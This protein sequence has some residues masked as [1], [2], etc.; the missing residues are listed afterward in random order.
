MIIVLKDEKCIDK[1]AEIPEGCHPIRLKDSSRALRCI[2]TNCT[3]SILTSLIN[4]DT[5]TAVWDF[6]VKTYSGVIFARKFQGIKCIATLQYNQG[7]IKRALASL[8]PTPRLLPKHLDRV[9]V[10]NNHPFPT[11]RGHPTSNVNGK[12]RNRFHL[13]VDTNPRLR[14]KPKLL[15]RAIYSAHKEMSVDENLVA[16]SGCSQSILMNKN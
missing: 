5:A 9:L 6:L 16:D 4:F 15:E 13:K 7:S 10:V 12:E 8:L 11:K 3:Q 1:D 14:K 2:T